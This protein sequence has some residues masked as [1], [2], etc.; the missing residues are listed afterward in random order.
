[1]IRYRSHDMRDTRTFAEDIKEEE[2]APARNDPITIHALPSP[3]Q[4]FRSRVVTRAA[5][6]HRPRLSLASRP[7]AVCMSLCHCLRGG[8]CHSVPA[9]GALSRAG[10]EAEAASEEMRSR[11]QGLDTEGWE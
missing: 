11:N 9:L 3:R 1:M 7:V 4:P 5:L 6:P 10:G 2:R 8:R